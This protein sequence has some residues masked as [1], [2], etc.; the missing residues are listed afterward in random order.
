LNDPEEV[1]DFDGSCPNCGEPLSPPDAGDI[2]IDDGEFV[3]I[4]QECTCG[5]KGESFY[6]WDRTEVKSKGT[7]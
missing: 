5:W 7:K 3:A 1:E 6:D 2:H 4:T